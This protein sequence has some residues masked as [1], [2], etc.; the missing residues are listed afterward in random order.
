MS[1]LEPPIIRDRNPHVQ[2]GWEV[3]NNYTYGT[4]TTLKFILEV[5]R[6]PGHYIMIA[7][8]PTILTAILTFVA[9]FLPLKSGGRIG[10]M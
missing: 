7:I 2:A 8:F 5:N 9:F 4:T 1:F 10:Y 6:L 3:V